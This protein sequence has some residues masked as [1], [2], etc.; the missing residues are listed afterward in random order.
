MTNKRPNFS[1]VVPVYN[2]EETLKKLHE[3][4]GGVFKKL[5]KSWE[6][7][8]VNDCSKDKSWSVIKDIAAKDKRVIAINLRNNFGQHNASM[9]G[10]N[11]AKGDYIITM[12]DDLQ[13]P[14][15]EI[16]RL[17][18]K[19][20]ENNYDIVYGQYT[21]KRHGLFRDL[22]SHL[23]NKSLAK[24]TG[25]GYKVTHFRIMKKC[26][27]EEIIQHKNY[28][29]NID[30]VTKDIVAPKNV[31]HCLVR[32]SIR[33]IGESNYSFRKLVLYAINMVFSFTIW[34][35]RIATIL[36][37]LFFGVSIILAVFY[38]S[39]YLFYGLEVSGWTSLSLSITFF[40]GM[41]LFMLGIIGEYVGKIFLNIIQKPQF[42]IKETKNW[43]SKR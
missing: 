6:L 35:L 7:V 1:V 2:S 32:H 20:K 38:F 9:C 4:L 11:F 31:G 3:R 39:Y 14:P 40:S 10:L 43:R 27:K 17:I 26:I 24:I 37:F 23:V 29:I 19:I 12:D 42:V 13:H 30:V 25:T 28:N 18:K 22:C 5:K 36:G 34:P 15:E 21:K 33:T 41:T 16:L 8:L